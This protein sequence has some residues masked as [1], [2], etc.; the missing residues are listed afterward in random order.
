MSNPTIRK[1]VLIDPGHGGPQ[2]GAVGPSGLKEKHVAL[3][4][5]G[6][7]R[8]RLISAADVRMTRTADV[9]ASLVVRADMA[10]NWR[11]DAFVSIHCNAAANRDAH[12]F[13]VFTAPGQNRSDVLAEE[14]I[15]AVAAAFPQMRIRADTTDGDR[16]KEANFTV[17]TRARVPAALVELAFISNPREEDLLRQ[18][19]FQER[20][21]GAIAQGITAFLA[22]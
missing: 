8:D 7:I 14:I 13:E 12:G 4:V 19:A 3:S 2:P 1:R 10:N 20:M 21:A 5:S 22:T 11:A 6:L 9:G 15:K 17:I 16:D 18:A